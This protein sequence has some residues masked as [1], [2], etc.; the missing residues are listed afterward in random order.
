MTKWTIYD[1]K[2]KALH[3]SI[4]EFNGDGKIVYQDTLEYSG[5]WMGERFL[6]VSIKS[7]YPIDFQ[8]GDYILY[9]G[10][11]FTINYDPTVIKKSSRGTYG[12]GFTYDSIKFN[13]PSN[14][15]TQMRFHDWVLSDNKLHYTSLPTF[16]F[17]A[18]D[19]DDLVDRLQAC[20]DRW[21]KDN[22]YPKE[23]YWMF[24]TLRNNT[25]TGTADPRQ[26]Q[27]TYQRTLSRAKDVLESC[28]IAETSDTGKAYLKDVQS[29][30]EK[31][32]GIGDNYTDSRDDERYDRNISVSNQSVWDGMA[33]IKQQFGL[34]FIVRGRNVY[35]GAA[36]IPTTHLFKYGKG[37]GLY[38]VDRTADQDQAVV[39]KLHAYGSGDN[40]P[41]RYYADLNTEAYAEI[42][43]VL[44]NNKTTNLYC[45]F[46]LDV[47]FAIRYFTN[48]LTQYGD[49]IYAVKIQVDD[50]IVNARAY[51][52]TD[53]KHII[54]YSECYA[55]ATDADDNTDTA[56]FGKFQ[57]AIV[58]GK[59]VIF[60]SGVKRD[61]WPVSHIT[62]STKNLPDNMAVNFL[63]LPGFPNNSL[64][65]ICRAEYDKTNDV[66]NY[67]ITNPST[68]TETLFHTESG[69]HLIKFSSDKYD[70]YI[71]SP[72]AEELGIKD[73]DI[74]CTEE[75]DDN[76]LEK[77]Y[78]TIEEITD[79]T[80][81]IG[82]TG[83]RLD[84]IFKAD[85]IDDN[86][87]FPKEKTEENIP[88]FHVW[89]P[90]L[91][92]DL[93]QAAKDAGGSEIQL[94]MKDGFCGGR[95]FSV[96]A[97]SKEKDGTWKLSCKRTQDNDLDLY[98][99]YSYA[100]SVSGVDDSMTNAYQICKGDH[101]VLTGISVSDVNYVWAA[102]V[103]LL[104][105]AIHWLCKNDYTRYVYQPK[106]D[107]IYMAREAVVA[108]KLGNTSLH[109]ALME[110]DILL[111]SDDDL[112][113]D[114]KVYIDQLNIKENGNNGI[115]TYE[116]TLRNEV[117]VGS[118]Q[119]LQ[120]Q[121]DSIATDVKKGNVGG[122]LTSPTQVASLIEAY[123]EQ[124]FVS[125]T[126]DDT[127]KGL[128]TFLKGFV[129]KA[130]AIF[131]NA[132]EIVKDLTVGG[133]AAIVGNASVG[134][135]STVKGNSTTDG[136][137][138]VGGSLTA[139]DI[140]S[141]RYSDALD[142]SS[143][144]GY[145]IWVNGKTS[146]AIFDNLSVRGKWI[147]SVLEVMKLQYSAGNITIDGAGGEIYAV[148]PFGKD[149]ESLIPTGN[150]ITTASA[151]NLLSDEG[152]VL[153]EDKKELPY[154][155]SDVFFYRCY[156][157]A[158]DGEKNILN[159]WHVGDQA[160]CQT[161]NLSDGTHLNAQ[162]KT[163]FR[164]VINKSDVTVLV[165]GTPCFYIDLSNVQNGTLTGDD[166][167]EYNYR[168]LLHSKADDGTVTWLA[169]DAPEK[170]DQ[171]AHVGNVYDEERQ[172]A[173]QLVAVGA[174][175]GLYVYDGINETLENLADFIHIKW[176]PKNSLLNSTFVTITNGY[177]SN[178]PYIYCGDWHKGV[179]AHPSE[180]WQYGGGSWVCNV[181]TQT[182]P[183][184][185][186]TET[187][188]KSDGTTEK[189]AA[190]SAFAQKGES[191]VQVIILTDKG[192]TLRQGMV[193]TTMT[194]HVYLGGEEITESIEPSKFSWYRT[195]S[196]P[197]SDVAWNEVHSGV[198]NVV[199]VTKS[200]VLAR[201]M[202]ECAVDYKQ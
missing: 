133:N 166:G 143:G 21:C 195:S 139:D 156:F 140:H 184:E 91:G 41:T 24:Y 75:N 30:W 28:G 17:Y 2:G 33:M 192:V 135:N 72:N 15:L 138:S 180:V 31:M 76:G 129:S 104:R 108:E 200:E 48:A 63:M 9:R 148:E 84:E 150:L 155:D 35:I 49:N 4:T 182:V 157:K 170:G 27:T 68:K 44:D 197:D 20:S 87:V 159:M 52:Q 165:D 101:Y 102:S 158:T 107:E 62:A 42:V 160:R 94:S 151:G 38:E 12:E 145:H 6:T 8:I 168:G 169:N 137:A 147:A 79:A 34:N 190:W 198:G 174:E 112:K 25:V 183:R 121:V 103:K 111:F 202:F 186:S 146:N 173:V 99:P 86:G 61:A 179:T 88:G 89:L 78:P 185:D 82:S 3:E 109:D 193:E 201:S 11:K 176:S 153:K 53:N 90:D 64:A 45:R 92:F 161:F 123:G 178:N 132:V 128:I 130:K 22:G 85:V 51:Q 162:N 194:A 13:S 196:N 59:R 83:N 136:N 142:Q 74:S 67:Y 65:D 122:G 81:G 40:L 149:G 175:K 70:P 152:K 110:G 144:I 71:V 26:T 97:V 127:A 98:F 105:K 116:V 29:K 181:K 124:W 113:I 57:N 93:K 32:Y 18:K 126:K 36:G 189:V 23:D 19:V 188:T 134:G 16:S 118:L 106:I 80:A 119:R 125:K 7:A 47:D 131:E 172:G 69:N 14:E 171:V 5:K 50:I 37:N 46:E 43:S 58:A 66:T 77:V 154:S 56:T 55:G 95:T 164:V 100:K 177:H 120:E 167:K 96:T 163:Y 54:I 199:K 10:E 60:L 191:A 141:R 115:P 187:I 114:G 1:R 73:F 117:T 39:T